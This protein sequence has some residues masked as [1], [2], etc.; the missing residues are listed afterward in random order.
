MRTLTTRA[1]AF[2]SSVNTDEV[3]RLL[4]AWPPQ[5]DVDAASMLDLSAC[6]NVDLGAG[7]RLV[8]AMRRWALGRLE[9]TVAP[10]IDLGGH[11]WFRLFTRSGLAHAIT[12]HA[13]V[14]HS[15]GQE[16]TDALRAHLAGASRPHAN[17][18]VMFTR[19]DAGAIAPSPDRFAR[20]LL[21][22]IR[23]YVPVVYDSVA[24]ADRRELTRLAHEAVI[25]VVDHAFRSPWRDQGE[26]LSY[27]SV[28]WYKTISAK[29]DE[30]GGLRGYIAAHR[31]GLGASETLAG[32]MEIVVAD[33]GVGVASRQSQ[34]DESAVYAAD[35]DEED[36]ALLEALES[37]ATVKLRT[38][39]AQI[40]GE[41]GY[42]MAIMLE[43]LRATGAYAA[44]RTG[45]RLIEFD[46]WRHDGFVLDE[47]EFG[48]LPG[49]AVHVVLPVLD[50]QLRLDE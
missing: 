23:E 6:R 19:L 13:A 24:S 44:V 48:W 42:G 26:R 17:T 31:D 28:R 3:E 1:H 37:N 5:A 9:V 43:C 34:S 49:T 33:D 18:C 46:P 35:V 40:R 20:I 4:L 8:N 2:G 29:N 25:N 22:A 36:R 30:L 45:R 14:V 41:P 27:L 50:P 12:T 21:D 38:L 47:Q 7:F 39:D 16:I 11:E 32:W 10:E 15:G